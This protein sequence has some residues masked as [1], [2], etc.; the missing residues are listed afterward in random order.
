M[1]SAV[2]GDPV[3]WPLLQDLLR[4]DSPA[5]I[6]LLFQ[7]YAVDLRDI[8]RKG[9]VVTSALTA[10]TAGWNYADGLWIGAHDFGR[11]FLGLVK[12]YKKRAQ[13]LVDYCQSGV[14]LTAPQ[15]QLT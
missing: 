12:K 11:A 5:L 15:L 6:T 1:S 8:T 14:S 10:G 3:A 4:N 9:K 7:L 2:R 13:A